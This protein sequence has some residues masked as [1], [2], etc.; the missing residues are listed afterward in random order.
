MSKKKVEAVAPSSGPSAEELML[1]LA[2]VD[3]EHKSINQGLMDRSMQ[4]A[5]LLETARRR[6]A[7]LEAELAHKNKT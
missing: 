7:A 6:I 4:Q 3:A 1:R 5:I 2:V